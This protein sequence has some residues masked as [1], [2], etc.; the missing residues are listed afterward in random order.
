MRALFLAAY[1]ANLGLT[2]ALLRQPQGH[3]SASSSVAPVLL[4]GAL[5]TLLAVAILLA[6]C[7]LRRDFRVPHG[8]NS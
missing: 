6:T 8:G 3:F 5:Y 2:Y 7:L 4:L 1:V